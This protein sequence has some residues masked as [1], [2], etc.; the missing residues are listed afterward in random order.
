M[1][2]DSLFYFIFSLI[3]IYLL[4]YIFLCPGLPLFFFFPNWG[5]FSHFIR[6]NMPMTNYLNFHL[7]ENVLVSPSFKKKKKIFSMNIQCRIDIY[8]R[9]FK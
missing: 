7:P 9:T 8:F 5:K 3:F 4:L 6:A 2:E 1:D